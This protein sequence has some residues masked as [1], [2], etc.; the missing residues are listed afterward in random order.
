MPAYKGPRFSCAVCGGQERDL[1]RQVIADSG[2]SVRWRSQV[3][4]ATNFVRDASDSLVR[5]M[6]R[7]R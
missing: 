5:M 3:A 4:N 1:L 6:S 7:C 2:L